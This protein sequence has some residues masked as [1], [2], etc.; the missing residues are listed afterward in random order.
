[1]LNKKQEISNAI[2]SEAWVVYWQFI[3]T[4]IISFLSETFSD[5]DLTG[6]SPFFQDSTRFLTTIGLMEGSVFDHLKAKRDAKAT[7]LN[8]INN[9]LK[10]Q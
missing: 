7:I 8:Q 4:S 6:F 1:M 3:D 5:C 10:K 9:K 2:R